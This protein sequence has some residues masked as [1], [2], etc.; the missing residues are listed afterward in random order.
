MSMT[1]NNGERLSIWMHLINRFDYT[2]YS[3]AC[4]GAGV[5]AHQMLEFA[6][7]AGIAACAI[8][9]YP[10]LAPLEAY[11]KLVI[12]NPSRLVSQHLNISASQSSSTVTSL[13]P[14][15]CGTCGGGKVL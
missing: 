6:Q 4:Q 15:P 8:V 5:E 3:R 1:S 13:A 11:W 12:E 9:A 10:D 2:E 14:P 7:K